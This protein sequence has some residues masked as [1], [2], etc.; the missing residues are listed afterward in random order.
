MGAAA[1]RRV[2][3][4][5]FLLRRLRQYLAE[6]KFNAAVLVDS[7]A[8]NLPI[9]SICRKLNIPVLYFIAPQTWAWGPKGWRNARVRKRVTRLACIW[10][11][12]EPYFRDAGIPADYVGHP[13]FDRLLGVKPTA[14]QIADMKGSA[15][16]LITLLPGS[17]QHVVD[18]VFPGQLEIARALAI[19]Y[20]NISFVVVAANAEMKAVIETA[21]REH[22]R[23]LPI[24]VVQGA[25]S[26]A[27]AIEAADLVLVA[28]GTIT[29]EVAYRG[30]PMLVMYNASR[31]TYNLIG[32]W[33]ITTPHLSIPNILAGRR[34]VPE[35]MPYYLNVDPII[36]AAVEWLSTPG[37]LQKVRED[38]LASVRPIVKGGASDQAAR[39]L[40]EMITKPS[41]T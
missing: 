30:A 3:E 5:Y 35:F 38:L 26:R 10:P 2:P 28:S 40:S 31:W 25:E 19:R 20:R 32:R 24:K 8:L 1:L 18:E 13:S 29:L 14:E 39:I 9:A 22:G 23:S 37:K 11:F 27:A 12:E 21:I 33:L 41:P 34:I 15:T 17:R 4:S 7:P 36:A 6:Q 16:P